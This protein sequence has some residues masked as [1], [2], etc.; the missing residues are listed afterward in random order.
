MLQTGLFTPPAKQQRVASPKVRCYRA[1][2]N[3]LK[4]VGA[5][6]GNEAL[7]GTRNRSYFYV[8]FGSARIFWI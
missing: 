3:P 7:P 6:S 2:L 8:S 5:S 1:L 4:V